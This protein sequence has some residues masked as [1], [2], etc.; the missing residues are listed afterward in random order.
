MANLALLLHP[1]QCSQALFERGARVDPMQLV[2]VDAVEFE[3]AKA[4][5]HAL[6]QVAGAAHDLG[7]G[8]SLAGDS[9]FGGDN[10]A[11][12]VGV[13]RLGD[14]ALGNLRAVG[15]GGVDEVH[16]Q[17]DGAA[18]DAVG[19][20]GVGGLAP[21]AISHQAH[22]AVAETVNRQVAADKESAAGGCGETVCAH[23]DLDAARRPDGC[24]NKAFLQ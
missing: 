4:H 17:L 8:R 20:G 19:F 18:E 23:A 6:D 21:G 16:A 24:E 1:P 7:F 15:V 14:Q 3:P 13:K 22:G 12:G 9:A 2:E 5:L 11:G 10:Q